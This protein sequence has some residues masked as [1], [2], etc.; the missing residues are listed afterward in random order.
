M[1]LMMSFCAL[2]LA[3]SANGNE[4]GLERGDRNN[5]IETGV[6]LVSNLEGISRE[7]QRLS[8]QATQQGRFRLAR[9]YRGVSDTARRLSSGVRLEVVFPLR[10][11]NRHQARQGLRRLKVSFTELNQQLRSLQR[12]PFSLENLVEQYH[13]LYRQLDRKLDG[14]HGPGPGPKPGKLTVSCTVDIGGNFFLPKTNVKCNVFGHGALGY[15]VT[16]NGRTVWN[17]ELNPRESRQVI[18]TDKQKVGGHAVTYD[19][20]VITR[21]GRQH[22]FTKPSLFN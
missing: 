8:V 11:G 18:Q 22:V 17:G 6:Q 15:E 20:Y 19:V 16:V 4:L 13:R 1:K 10:R 2:A 12:V 21:Q 14:G 9:K 7:S 3:L 5:A